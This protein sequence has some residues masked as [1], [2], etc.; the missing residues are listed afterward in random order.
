MVRKLCNTSVIKL[1]VCFTYRQLLACARCYI[2]PI[3][4]AKMGTSASEFLPQANVI[5]NTMLSVYRIKV[6]LL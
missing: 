5:L 2:N 1:N 4:R 6:R 3:K